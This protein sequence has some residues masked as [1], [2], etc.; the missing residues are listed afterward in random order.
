MITCLLFGDHEGKKPRTL[1]KFLNYVVQVSVSLDLL[2]NRDHLLHI[3]TCLSCQQAAESELQMTCCFFSQECVLGELLV[4]PLPSSPCFADTSTPC[5]LLP[6]HTSRKEE[7]VAGADRP[8][9]RSV[10]CISMA[11]ISLLLL[12]SH[13][14]SSQGT[15]GQ[16]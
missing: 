16:P 1:H 5:C 2:C 9:H 15:C 10:L 6:P 3:N 7:L 13:L 8:L 11:F 14:P 4:S 12:A